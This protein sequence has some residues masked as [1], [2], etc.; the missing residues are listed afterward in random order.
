[1]HDELDEH[2][3]AGTEAGGDGGSHAQTCKDSSKTLSVVPAPLH[4]GRTDGCNTDTSNGGDEGVGG[5][6]VG[7]VLGAPH[8][9][10]GSSRE[11]TGESKHL[12][13]GITA[14]G[15]VGDDTVLDGVSRASTD[16][17]GTEHLE[18]GAEDHGLSVGDRSGGDTSSP[19]VGHIIFKEVMS[20][21]LVK[22]QE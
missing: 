20:A 12:N 16:R 18:D 4:L 13:T 9:P 8:N 5:R 2:E 1:M 10:G 19:G 22:E 3:Y 15:R 21:N 11:G 14:E 17:D 7:R 6:D